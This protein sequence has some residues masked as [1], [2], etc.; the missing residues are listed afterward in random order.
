MSM[1]AVYI[2]TASLITKYEGYAEKAYL[3]TD[4]QYRVGYGRPASK[5]EQ[6]W[7]EKKERAWVHL[8]GLELEQWILQKVNCTLTPSQRAALISFVYNVGEGA[9]ANSRML[10]LINN[11]HYK[12]A[13]NEFQR[14]VYVDGKRMGGLVKRRAAEAKF[15]RQGIGDGTVSCGR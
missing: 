6:A 9:F 4:N 12:L 15:F 11:R 10:Y 8:K 5:G 14:W 7:D 2:A 1:L 13:A 3:D